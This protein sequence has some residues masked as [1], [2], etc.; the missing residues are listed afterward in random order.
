MFRIIS[1]RPII[2]LSTVL[3]IPLAACSGGGG[4][5]SSGVTA[6]IPIMPQPAQSSSASTTFRVVIPASYARNVITQSITPKYISAGIMSLQIAVTNPSGVV[7]PFNF[8]TTAS[9]PGCT[10]DLTGNVTCVETVNVPIGSDIFTV[11]SYAGAGETGAKLSTGSITQTIVASQANSVNFTLNGIVAKLTIS[12]LSSSIS[13][14]HGAKS[15][16]ITLTAFDAANYAIIGSATYSVPI[17]LAADATSAPHVV[18]SKT[19][20]ATP[21]DTQNLTLTY[22]G[23]YPLSTSNIITVTAS[24]SGLTSVSTTIALNPPPLPV[25]SVNPFSFTAAGQSQTANITE[26]DYSG[27][28]TFNSASCPT[29]V[30]TVSTTLTSTTLNS[31][32]AGQCSVIVSDSFGNQITVPVTVTL[33]TFTVN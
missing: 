15:D 24:A 16:G 18:F 25:S 19:T 8:D 13:G 30:V 5:S 14:N 23:T 4:M 2:A 31:Q 9:A 27:T 29:N 28:W 22:D 7:T 12:A 1:L 20:I 33:T 11:T 32:G 6:S 17:T 21:A 26:A 10:T 3:M